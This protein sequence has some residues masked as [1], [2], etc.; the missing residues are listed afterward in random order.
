[1]VVSKFLS[2]LFLRTV[3]AVFLL[4]AVIYVWGLGMVWREGLA[5]ILFS[6]LVLEWILL[7]GR[8][9]TLKK[10]ELRASIL[11]AVGFVYIFLSG[12]G[13]WNFL[14]HPVYVTL[15]PGIMLV[16]WTVDSGAY[17]IGSMLK[18]PKL[19]PSISAGKT[20]SGFVGGVLLGHVVGYSFIYGSSA[21]PDKN[22]A[23]I[24]T[25][26]IPFLAQFGDLL[27]SKAKRILN[28]KDSSGLIPGHGGILDRLDSALIIFF[29][30]C[31][32]LCF[33]YLNISIFL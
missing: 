20:W 25:F 8:V 10:G 27:E 29:L 1:M 13:F 4:A 14:H 2:E 18:G 3:S 6:F 16:L 33:Q 23:F 31:V 22:T 28:V 17:L 15:I 24:V 11:F 26:F 7:W 32:H 30:W 19:A 5:L 9:T 12:V 21:F